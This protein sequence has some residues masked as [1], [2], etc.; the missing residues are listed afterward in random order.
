M[1]EVNEILDW[2][3]SVVGPCEVVSGDARFHGRTMV[4]QLRTASG[5]CYL[6]V[7]RQ[8]PSWEAEVHGYE[9]WAP[10][11]DGLVPRLLA[12]R[13]EEPLALLVSE[14][15]GRIMEQMQLPV[16]R[17]R[18]VWRAAGRALAGLHSFAVGRCFG[19]CARDGSCI[20]IPV[21]DARAYM[22]AELERWTESGLRTGCINDEELAVI[23]A[24]QRLI[25]AFAG[26]RPTPCHRDY[27]PA[28][29]LVSDDG[30]WA[31]VIDFE[32]AHWDVRV[33][34]F[35][36]YPDWEWIRRPDLLEALFDG[37]GRPLTAEE[38]QQSLVT[39]T[40]Y[41]LSAIVWGTE[42]SFHGFAEEG[43][44]AFNHLADL[45]R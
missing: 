12:V 14:L 23:R 38:E 43:R 24:A 34:D 45:L 22:S 36:R 16:R 13:E 26:E 37:Y 7:H 29:W 10:A 2:C 11:L 6:K 42:H 27:C 17:E 30:N 4:C 32:L 19:P 9:Q 35:S 33:A 28:N 1:S 41:A 18:M 15:P 8:R 44:Q 40:R 39:R 31:G 25:P 20:G 21:D 5:H 3:T